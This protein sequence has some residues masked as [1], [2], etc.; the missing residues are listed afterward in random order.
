MTVHLEH[1]GPVALV[2][3]DRPERR[4]AV[5]HATLLELQQVH[6]DVLAAQIRSCATAEY[7]PERTPPTTRDLFVSSGPDGPP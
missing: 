7:T 5:D 6:R 4:N 1:R 3:L 2:T